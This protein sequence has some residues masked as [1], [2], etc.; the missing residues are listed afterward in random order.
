VR[1]EDYALIGDTHSAGLVS[2]SGSIDWLCLPRFDSGSVF[3]ALL[4]EHR[5][6]R[7]LISPRDRHSVSRGY[8]P[9]SMVLET[10]FETPEGAAL[11]VDCLPLEEHS[12]PQVPRQV[13][14]HEVVVRVVRGLRGRVDMRMLY[15]PRFDYGSIT[16][17]VRRH[18]DAIEAIG[19]PEALVL[20]ADPPVAIERASVTASFAVEEGSMARF[21]AAYR[22]SHLRPRNPIGLDAVEQLV[23][24]TDRYW[25][26][27]AGRCRYEGPWRKQVMRS[28]LTLKALTYSPTGGIVAAATT[29]LPEALGGVRNWDYRYCWLRDATFTLDVL[30]DRGYT[31]E[32]QEWRAWLLRAVA[33][34]PKDLQIMYGVLG[35]RRLLEY[36]L[37]WLAGYEDS[38]PVRVGNAAH[39]Q[40]QLDVYGEVMDSFHSA[41]RAGLETKESAWELERHIVEFVCDNWRAP[42]DGIW[43]VRSGPQHFVHSKV[44]AWVAVDRGIAA[45]EQSG[46]QGPLERWK[47]VRSA[48]F[49]E[50]LE[51][52]YS[53]QRGT[54]VRAY[55]SDELDASLLMLPLVGFLPTEDPRVRATVDAIAEELCADGFV[56]RYQ[57]HETAD[58]LPPGE[59]SFLMCTYWLADCLLMLGRQEEAKAILERLLGLC[60]DVG[61]LSEQYDTK[62]R[63][64][65]GN[66]PQ[67]FSHTALVTSAA[68]L[69]KSLGLAPS[70]SRAR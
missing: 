61:L 23:E 28:L 25:R 55:G 58:G 22:P 60:N 41:R 10:R 43:E 50:V 26:E 13:F 51:R 56:L 16:P 32:A 35:E 52:G 20:H 45:I 65:V 18:E 7:W 1:L 68:L 49:E 27:W 62:R 59:G 21:I 2:S 34:D 30:L 15:E 4:D 6:G 48:I 12:D 57:S 54:F 46:K 63:R 66:F 3:G 53:P 19:G 69:A 39:G 29:S 40:F 36:E 33:G 8:R 11:L 64:L 37:P 17:W 31:A 14:P 38:R 67:A 24:V 44:M 70:L 5:G 9:D 47:K 42:D